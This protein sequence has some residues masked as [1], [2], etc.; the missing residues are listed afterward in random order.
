MGKISDFVERGW[1][2][3]KSWSSVCS[4]THNQA[5]N[6]FCISFVAHNKLGLAGY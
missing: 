6:L 1:I 2:I 3:N 5:L 4:N